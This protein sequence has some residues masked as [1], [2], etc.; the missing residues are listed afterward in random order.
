MDRLLAM[1]REM[2]LPEYRERYT[3][4]R[5][6]FEHNPPCQVLM[7]IMDAFCLEGEWFTKVIT[8]PA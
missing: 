5:G 8:P 1:F 7:D 4:W 3:F 2:L 6:L